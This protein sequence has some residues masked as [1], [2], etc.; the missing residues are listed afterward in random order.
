[1]NRLPVV[2]LMFALA[3][4]SLFSAYAP[5]G[6]FKAINLP[7]GIL[8]FFAV[9]FLLVGALLLYAAFMPTASPK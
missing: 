2:L 5:K 7:K 9:V 8:I 3:A 4:L 1:M 6:S